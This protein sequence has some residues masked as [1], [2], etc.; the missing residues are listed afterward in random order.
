MEEARA[1]SGL[2]K[3]AAADPRQPAPPAVALAQ[4]KAAAIT[5]SSGESGESGEQAFH[6]RLCCHSI[7]GVDEVVEV[8]AA[9]RLMH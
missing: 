6:T 4:P 5:H 8:V 3:P 2:G 7:G 1:S 9:S